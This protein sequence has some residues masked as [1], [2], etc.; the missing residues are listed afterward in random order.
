MPLPMARTERPIQRPKVRLAIAA[1]KGGVGKS[2]VTA[3]LA[4]ALQKRGRSV[5]V[6]DTDLYG[7]SLRR[8]LP[9][10]ERPGR[11]GDLL[12]PAKSRGI[13]LMSMAYFREE[14]QAAAVRAPIAN[15]VITQFLDGVDWEPVDYLLMDFPPGTGDIQL[16]LAQRAHVSAALLVTTP[17]QIALQDVRKAASLFDQLQ[18]PLLGVV[19]NMSYLTREDGKRLAVFGTGG[20]AEIARERGI[21]LLGQLPLDPECCR[22]ADEGLSLQEESPESDCATSF[23]RLAER[24][25]LEVQHICGQQ[26]G[27]LEEFEVQWNQK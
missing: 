25:E 16:T 20:G 8:M 4:F 23:M 5:A 24:V 1:G 2:T 6:L 19:E 3:N 10:D 9:E 15:Q 14:G 13:H 7:P 18:I 26:E 21:P 22:V 27:S 17:Q 12:V 11:R